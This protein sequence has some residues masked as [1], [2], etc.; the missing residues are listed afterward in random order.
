GSDI[1]E[2]SLY[3]AEQNIRQSRL[4]KDI[5]LRL[6]DFM[7]LDPPAEKGMIVCN[8]PYG[9]RLEVEDIIQMYQNIG[10]KLKNDYQNWTAWFISSD[11]DAMKR[12]GLHPSK[13]IELYN[14]P[15]LCKF[16]K[17]ELYEGSRKKS[18]NAE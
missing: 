2:E 4:H 12:F 17:F 5:S 1:S 11:A 10:D 15:L 3:I 6:G 13:K 7:K 9:V 18:K 8:P 16:Q 14:G